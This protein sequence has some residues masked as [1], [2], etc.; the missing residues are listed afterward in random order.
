MLQLLFDDSILMV[1]K[2]I[3]AQITWFQCEFRLCSRHRL[4]LKLTIRDGQNENDGSKNQNHT[5]KEAGKVL[6]FHRCRCD[7]V[8]TW[9]EEYQI[10]AQL[11]QAT[12]L[13][14]LRAAKTIAIKIRKQNLLHLKKRQGT[15]RDENKKKACTQMD[16]LKLL[17]LFYTE[18]FCLCR[19]FFWCHPCSTS[20][21][22]FL[23]DE[24]LRLQYFCRTLMLT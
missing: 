24:I 22:L 18:T 5:K 13:S 19:L 2:R 9:Q 1:S 6:D 20:F 21:S 12:V 10:K 14:T 7:F 8:A 16:I 11:L 3:F 23:N 17:R 4:K 15:Y